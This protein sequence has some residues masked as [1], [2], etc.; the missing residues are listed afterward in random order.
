MGSDIFLSYSHADEVLANEFIDLAASRGLTVW[1]DQL[2]EGGHDWRERIVEALHA[3]GALVILFSEHS[4]A[5]TQLIKELAIADSLRKRVIP[6]L[7]AKSEPR[8]AYLYELAARNWINLFPS[9]QTRLP[10]LIDKLVAEL[11][12]RDKQPKLSSA[13]ENP[14][15]PLPKAD[16]RDVPPAADIASQSP[17]A[18]LPQPSSD[19]SGWFP[20]DR[21]DLYILAPLL[22]AAFSLAVFGT[23]DTSSAGSGFIIIG[24]LVYIMVI[25]VRNARLNR[26]MSSGKSF[27]SYFAV[28]AIASSSTLFVPDGGMAI[29]LGLLVLSFIG[30]VCANVLQVALRRVFQRNL[31][32]RKIAEPI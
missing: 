20:M 25:A 22:I 8:G 2:I 27:A 16:T 7:I 9:P 19:D 31:F 15:S 13:S 14:M 10:A 1:Y 12:I 24:C 18:S 28:L 26:S 30:A 6:V 3:S 21:R 11:K 29:F 5:S 23:G 17:A 32:K 4:N